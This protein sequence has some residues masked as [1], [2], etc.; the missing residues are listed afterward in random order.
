MKTIVITGINGTL[1]KALGK[2]YLRK[3]WRVVGVSRSEKFDQDSCTVLCT[4]QQQNVEDAQQ[5][6]SYDPDIIIL[7][8]GQIET[9]IGA[10]G[11]PLQS[12]FDS[13][14]QINYTF[15]ATVCLQAAEITRNRRLDIIGI[16]SIADGSPSCFGPV[17]H[18]SK[19]A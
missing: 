18:A 8:A 7:N 14:T 2:Y 9:E 3:G 11:V 12:Q 6:L 1:G 13:I 19:I 16:G 5:L 17:Y 4:N 15:P 10:G